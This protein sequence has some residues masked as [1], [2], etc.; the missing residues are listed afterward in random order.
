MYNPERRG[1]GSG[2]DQERVIATPEDKDTG[3]APLSGAPIKTGATGPDARNY[4]FSRAIFKKQW[5]PVLQA[6]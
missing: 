1:D 6:I 3:P 2:R 5:S 4:L